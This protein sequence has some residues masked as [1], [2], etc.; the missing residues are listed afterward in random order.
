[1]YFKKLKHEDPDITLFN[2]I[3]RREIPYVEVLVNGNGGSFECHDENGKCVFQRNYRFKDIKNKS[4]QEII[5]SKM[6]KDRLSLKL[7]E[8]L[9]NFKKTKVFQDA[10]GGFH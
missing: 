4:L 10:Y 9:D 5:Y 1:M 8:L 6:K 3:K 2:K 7:L